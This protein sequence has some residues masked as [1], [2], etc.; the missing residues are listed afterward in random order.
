MTQD[1][2][3]RKT[4]SLDD[5]LN[6]QEG[7]DQAEKDDTPFVAASEEGVKVIGD[8]N[9]TEVKSR[10]YAMRFRFPKSEAS[11]IDEKDIVQEV[12]DE[13]IV[14]VEFNDVHIMPRRDLEV[15]DAILQILPYFKKLDDDGVNIE[16]LKGAELMSFL[17][18]ANE[19]VGD[20]MYEVAAAVLNID[21]NL[22]DHMVLTDVFKMTR[23][24]IDDFPEVFNEADV[25]FG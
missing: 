25:F 10:N 12:A 14:R 1:E 6:I 11:N 22:R 18:N 7:M 19:Q 4:V 17:R 2:L 13:V 5:M 9:K 8:A 20:A 24:F 21:R 16:N 3:L 23:R 15:V